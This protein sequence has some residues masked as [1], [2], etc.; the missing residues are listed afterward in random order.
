M[1]QKRRRFSAEFKKEAV[2]QI[3]E[4]GRSLHEVSRELD[5]QRR[6]LR[7]WRRQVEEAGGLDEAFGSGEE[8]E[9]VRLRRDVRRLQMENEFLKKAEAY[10]KEEST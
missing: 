8:P 4:G 2:R 10:F 1:V 6:L 5:V 9:V 3:L 7:Y